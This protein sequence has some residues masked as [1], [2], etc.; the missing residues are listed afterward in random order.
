MNKLIKRLADEA[1]FV[2]W[3]GEEHAPAD[4][5]IDWSCSYDY[6]LEK[7]AEL[8]IHNCTKEIAL[9][10]MSNYDN[11]DITWTAEKAISEIKKKFD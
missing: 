7:F 2:M 1:G 3:N 10:G 9:L 4:S 8:I 6:E 5:V 11:E